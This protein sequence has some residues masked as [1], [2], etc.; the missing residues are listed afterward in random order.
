MN[1]NPP[2]ASQIESVLP[3]FNKYLGFELGKP[4]NSAKVNPLILAEMKTAA[5][6]VGAMMDA[7]G[8]I[9]GT[10]T[11]NWDPPPVD[12]GA[13]GADYLTRG[14]N[15]VL[16]LTANTTVEAFYILGAL[17]ANAAPLDGNKAYTITFEASNPY[18]QAIPPGFWSVTMYDGKTKLTVPNPINRYFLGS[19]DDMKKNADRSVTM[20]L[21]ATSP[22]KDLESN[23]LPS[24]KGPFYLLLRNYAPTA[25]ADK[26][27]ANT[28]KYLM[29][30]IV[31]VGGK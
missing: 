9:V 7:V 28:G 10:P 29:P 3:I 15:S 26:A 1:E 12:F 17:D 21:Q 30:P 4:W 20:H 19:A 25:E 13:T 16:G 23:W 22:G 27:L 18:I 31:P 11:S 2:P 6:Q 24:P 8:P 5:Q 14:I